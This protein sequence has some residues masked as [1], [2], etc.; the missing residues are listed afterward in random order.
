MGKLV[1]GMMQ[2]L[3][4]YI[5]GPSG[6]PQVFAP[7]PRLFRPFIDYVSG[8]AGM[9]YGTQM[10]EVMRYWDDDHP[11]WEEIEH[12]FAAAWRPKPK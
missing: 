4:G 3:D 9:L 11:E 2:P 7:G 1:F 12:E 10:Y 5:A 8:L 6:G